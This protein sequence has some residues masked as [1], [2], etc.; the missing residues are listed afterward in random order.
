MMHPTGTSTINP[1]RMIQRPIFVSIVCSSGN[2][3]GLARPPA[4]RKI[5]TH[6][7]LSSENCP[8]GGTVAAFNFAKRRHVR[9]RLSE[10]PTLR[11]RLAPMPMRNAANA[12][13]PVFSPD[14]VG[15]QVER[16]GTFPHVRTITGR[17][18]GRGYRGLGRPENAR[19]DSLR[20]A[21]A[22][23]QRIEA[24]GY[25]IARSTLG[26]RPTNRRR[27][28]IGRFLEVAG[29]SGSRGPLPNPV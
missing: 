12:D 7:R 18:F 6:R 20:P 27:L 26:E 15:G 23:Q 17:R 3:D 16:R 4:M 25:R 11:R 2:P 9:W 1:T 13:S 29:L 5:A 14:P 24:R 28:P 10:K 21:Q 8:P 22:Y 19:A